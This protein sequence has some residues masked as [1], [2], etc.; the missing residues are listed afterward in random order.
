VDAILSAPP[1]PPRII[2][3]RG[4]ARSAPENTLAGLRRAH[5]L[6]ARWVE[7]DVQA[8]RDDCPILLHDARLERTTDGYGVAAERSAAEIAKLDAGRWFGAPFRGEGVPR[9]EDAMALLAAL[10]IGAVIEVKAAPGAGA[11][12]MRATLA[13]LDRGGT[14]PA[15]ILS[16]FAADALAAAHA[17]A[18]LLPRALIVKAVPVDWRAQVARLG[19][20]ALHADHRALDPATVAAVAAEL[21]IRA[22]TVNAPARARALFAWGVA[23]VFADCPDVLISALGHQTGGPADAGLEGSRKK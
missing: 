21:P 7:F 19:C 16:S 13:A 2:G 6:G 14:P 3:H 4:A 8:T 9:L 22:Y 17:A 5:A 20:T 15:T 1:P 23:A 12:V 10:G 18:P 11:R